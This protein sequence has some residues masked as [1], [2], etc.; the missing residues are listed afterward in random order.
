MWA[1]LPLM[2]LL[3]ILVLILILHKLNPEEP[4]VH[5]KAQETAIGDITRVRE[6]AAR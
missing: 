4:D 5:K 1:R 6:L 2:P 3:L